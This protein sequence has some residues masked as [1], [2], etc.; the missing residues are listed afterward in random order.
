MTQARTS[1]QER[2]RALR[3]DFDRSFSEPHQEERRE[4]ESFIA[5]RLAGDPYA[6]RIRDIAAL[7]ARPRIV[8]LPSRRPEFLGLTGHGGSL[9]ALFGLSLL[10]GYGRSPSLVRW[11]VLPRRATALALGFE[12][13]EGYAQVAMSEI[14]AVGDA[15]KRR[16]A[17]HAA[18]HAGVV[19]LIVDLPAVVD[20]LSREK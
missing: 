15:A 7:G 17:T 4:F 20:A 11:F 8:P 2:A 14:H 6:L 1:G 13:Y 16:Y 18:Q 9:A 3:A 12:E 19:R 10:L 5:V